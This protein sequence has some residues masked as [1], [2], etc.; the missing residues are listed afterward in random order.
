MR[1]TLVAL[2]LLV[3][4][5][6]VV[7]AEDPGRKLQGEE[8]VSHYLRAMAHKSAA[9]VAEAKARYAKAPDAHKRAPLE[10]ALGLPLPPRVRAYVA[11]ELGR[12]ADERSAPV[13]Q[14]WSV[15]DPKASVRAASVDAL[16]KIDARGTAHALSRALRSRILSDRV[17]AAEALGR[18]GE[19]SAVPHVLLH[20]SAR[21]GD[22]PRAY[23]EQI[24]QISYVA[25]FDVEIA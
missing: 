15:R 1:T 21:A 10:A 20:W 9:I 12:L 7:A 17:R 23:F 5:P 18:L 13:L 22:F 11:G 24:N 8:R 25:D 2:C 6:T 3:G 19:L 4:V 14:K 16:K